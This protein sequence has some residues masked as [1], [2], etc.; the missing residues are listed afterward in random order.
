MW[1]LGCVCYVML[2][3][4]LP[5]GGSRK[6]VKKDIKDGAYEP[7]MGPEWSAVSG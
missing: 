3:G 1:S 4:L 6:D 2:S 5:F 7:M